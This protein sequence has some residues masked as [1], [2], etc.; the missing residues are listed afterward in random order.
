M[1]PIALPVHDSGEGLLNM[2][3]AERCAV[4]SCW[5]D[6]WRDPT[7]LGEP[8]QRVRL[9]PRWS[10]WST[11]VGDAVM[12][13]FTTMAGHYRNVRYLARFYIGLKMQYHG[14]AQGSEFNL[15]SSIDLDREELIKVRISRT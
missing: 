2:R 6:S 15:D 5:F 7:L 4:K 13:R 11:F 12:P 8:P 3:L 1:Y 9:L 10:S 14:N